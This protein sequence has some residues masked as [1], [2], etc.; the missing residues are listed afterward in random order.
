VVVTAA[1]Y[2]LAWHGVVVKGSRKA[3]SSTYA[4]ELCVAQAQPEAPEPPRTW[5]DPSPGGYYRGNPDGRYLALT[6]EAARAYH[7]VFVWDEQAGTLRAVLSIQEADPGSGS[8]H[9]YRW[10]RDGKALLIYG[11]GSLPFESG[12]SALSYAYLPAE[13]AI[14]EL[15]TCK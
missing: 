14:Y 9:E 6:R 4:A 11:R 7:T 1:A 10:S 2:A 15:P 8:S 3:G 5:S 12:P 13:D